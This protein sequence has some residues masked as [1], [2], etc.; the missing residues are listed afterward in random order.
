MA[1]RRGDAN[2]L[3]QLKQFAEAGDGYAMPL[4]AD[5]YQLGLCGEAM[6]EAK[7]AE[8]NRKGLDAGDGYAMANMAD[9]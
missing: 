1:I 6:D 8:L 2:A 4:I 5:V 7:E 9:E 3:G